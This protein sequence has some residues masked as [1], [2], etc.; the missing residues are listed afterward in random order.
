MPPPVRPVVVVVLPDA[1]VVAAAAVSRLTPLKA[2][3]S[4]LRTTLPSSIVMA[5]LSMPS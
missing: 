3:S 4:D 2:S 5:L 1:E